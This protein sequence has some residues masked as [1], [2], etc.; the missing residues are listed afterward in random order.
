MLQQA[1]QE[2]LR[3]SR[4]SVI[5]AE[6]QG[7]S[8]FFPFSARQRQ[9]ASL[10]VEPQGKPKNTGV[11]ILALLQRI[12]LAQESN[13]GLLHCRQILYQLSHRGSPRILDW[14]KSMNIS[15]RSSYGVHIRK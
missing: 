9:M 10:P 1:R 8:S 2:R 14:Y 4:A 3:D 6:H 5:F 15:E 12:F 11:G 13:W 7:S